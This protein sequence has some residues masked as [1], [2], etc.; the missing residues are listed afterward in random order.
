MISPLKFQY[1]SFKND[2]QIT[3]E[4]EMYQMKSTCQYWRN[5]LLNKQLAQ[6]LTFA[7]TYTM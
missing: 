4:V 1:S 7:A 6:R 2:G 3:A 5:L